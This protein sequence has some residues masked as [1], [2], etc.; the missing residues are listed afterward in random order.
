M[1]NFKTVATILTCFCKDR[2]KKRRKCES[3]VIGVYRVGFVIVDKT[4]VTAV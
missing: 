1:F 3:P 4:V 2:L